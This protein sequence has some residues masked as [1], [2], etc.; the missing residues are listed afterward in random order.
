MHQLGYIMMD[1]DI[2]DFLRLIDKQNF[3]RNRENGR[4]NLGGGKVVHSNCF[5]SVLMDFKFRPLL[6]SNTKRRFYFVE[7]A[8]NSFQSYWHI[9]KEQN[10]NLARCS[11]TFEKVH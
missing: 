6:Y 2:S 9:S 11:Y 8:L 5:W 3:V 7:T 4:H 1:I 10:N